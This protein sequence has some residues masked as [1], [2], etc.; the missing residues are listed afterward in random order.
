MGKR[1]QKLR[2][3][4]GLSMEDDLTKYVIKRKCHDGTEKA[5]RIQRLV[6]P[7]TKAKR[8]AQRQAVIAKVVA[9]R[10]E[11]KEWEKRMAEFKAEKREQRAIELA[12]KKAAKEARLAAKEAK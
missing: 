9:N 6:T 1:A 12:K 8:E 2:K 4:F 7:A 3:L 10:E 5:P 11:Q